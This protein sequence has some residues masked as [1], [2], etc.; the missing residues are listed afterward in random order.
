GTSWA[1]AA[2]ATP[3]PVRSG[4]AMAYDAAAAGGRVVL[5]GGTAAGGTLNDT[6]TWD[7]ANWRRAAGARPPPARS[8]D[9]VVFEAAGTGGRVV[10][11]G[12]SSAGG[13]LLNDIWSWD[14]TAWTHAAPSNPPLPRYDQATAYDAARGQVVLFGGIG[15]SAVLSDTWTWDGA[16]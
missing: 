7:G 5:F 14:D 16:I 11:F 2:P 6:W 3:P 9:A 4:H 10:L 12:G 15:S 1:Q 8:G 13:T